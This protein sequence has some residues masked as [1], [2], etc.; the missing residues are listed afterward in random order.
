MS[1]PPSPSKSDASDREIKILAES[2]MYFVLS[3][4]LSNDQGESVVDVLTSISRSLHSISRSLA[5]REAS[6]K[7]TKKKRSKS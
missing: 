7:T 6:R 2:P 1:H 4:F 3:K 5:S